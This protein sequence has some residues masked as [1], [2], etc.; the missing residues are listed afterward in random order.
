[1]KKKILITLIIVSLLA[2]VTSVSIAIARWQ[3]VSKDLQD[4][5]TNLYTITLVADGSS[6]I[7]YE[8]LESDSL[9]FLPMASKEGK[10]FNGWKQNATYY[11]GTNNEL[12]FEISVSTIIGSSTSHE[13]TLNAEFVDVPTGH[14][15][16]KIYDGGSL[17]KQVLVEKDETKFYAFNLNVNTKKGSTYL[18]HFTTSSIKHYNYFD[19]EITSTRIDLNDYFNPN[20][21]LTNQQ[22]I[23]LNAVYE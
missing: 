6:N 15:L 12:S 9:I 17:M 11:K 5:D 13:F 2:L 7:V 14:V 8:N 23:V 22:I 19:E 1:M 20:V 4:V 10:Y 16:F 18:S 3:I 21:D